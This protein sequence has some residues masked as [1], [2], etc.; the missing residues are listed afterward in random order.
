MTFTKRERRLIRLRHLQ[1]NIK[2]VLEFLERE[3]EQIEKGASQ[4]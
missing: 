1:T 3:I 2:Q 4:E